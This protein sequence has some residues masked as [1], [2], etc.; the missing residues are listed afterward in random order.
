MNNLNESA[1][2]VLG[3]STKTGY[4]KIEDTTIKLAAG[5]LANPH[6]R[7]DTPEQLKEIADKASQ[8]AEIILS[9]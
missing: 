1:F 4:S 7:A 9:K 3:T 5:L 6:T 8:L 2:P